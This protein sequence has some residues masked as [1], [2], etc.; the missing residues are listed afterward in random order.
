[1]A[2]H[3]RR[4]FSTAAGLRP[5]QPEAPVA[6]PLPPIYR[7]PWPISPKEKIPSQRVWEKDINREFTND[8]LGFE[9]V[10]R[11]VNFS[12]VFAHHLVSLKTKPFT[13]KG[14]KSERVGSLLTPIFQHFRISFE[15]EEVNTTRFTMDETYLKNSHWLKGNLLWTQRGSS[16]GSA[17]TQTEDEFIDPAGGPR[18]G[19][20]SSALPYE[21]SSPPPILMEPQVFQQYVVDSFKSARNAIA[22]LCRF[23]C[24]APTRRRHRSPAPTSGLEHED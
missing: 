8:S 12:A 24:V 13:G 14:K 3:P 16:S 2:A 17:P 15:G 23:G 9:E 11:D 1:M 19:S 4:S 6:A 7:F 18:V 21:L 22:T 20:S 10:D 5:S